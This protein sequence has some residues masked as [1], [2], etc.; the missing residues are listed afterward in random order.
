MVIL[1]EADFLN[2]SV[3]VTQV[4]DD[5]QQPLGFSIY[6]IG[7]GLGRIFVRLKIKL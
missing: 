5:K 2:M 3:F 1:N 6:G 7:I 4:L